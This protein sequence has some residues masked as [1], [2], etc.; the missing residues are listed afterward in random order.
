MKNAAYIAISLAV[1]AALHVSGVLNG[2]HLTHPV[3]RQ[4]ATLYGSLGGAVLAFA[5]CWACAAKPRLGRW[6]RWLVMLGF[7]VAV[8]V[9]LL[10]ARAF[11]L[12]EDFDPVAVNLWHKRSYAVFALFVPAFV[13]LLAKLR[14]IGKGAGG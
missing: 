9:S 13:A 14:I 7:L 5:M 6:L 3:W 2:T 8:A 1:V 11:I 12:A 4:N 10:N